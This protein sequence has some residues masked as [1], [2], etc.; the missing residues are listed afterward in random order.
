MP[1]KY[2]FCLKFCLGPQQST[3]LTLNFNSEFNFEYTLHKIYKKKFLGKNESFK[4][5]FFQN[6]EKKFAIFFLKMYNP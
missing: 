2:V 5:K 4:K 3:Q 1:A 6:F